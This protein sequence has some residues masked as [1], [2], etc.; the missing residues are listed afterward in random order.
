MCWWTSIRPVGATGAGVPPHPQSV[1]AARPS[2]DHRSM[3]RLDS[4]RTAARR[5]RPPGWREGHAAGPD[6]PGFST[7]ARPRRRRRDAQRGHR[8]APFPTAVP[9]RR[10]DHAGAR[11]VGVGQ[12]GRERRVGVPGARPG[13]NTALLTVGGGRIGCGAV[14]RRRGFFQQAVWSRRWPSAPERSLLPRSSAAVP[15]V[16]P[17]DDGP[18][19]TTGRSP[20]A[21]S[22]ST[23]AVSRTVWHSRGGTGRPASAARSVP[24]HHGDGPVRGARRQG[25]R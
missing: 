21:L 3:S 19:V 6:R 10:R 13:R 4:S 23:T 7:S 20:T 8:R 25:R 1:A 14:V 16:A 22:P 5:S 18:I 2:A 15:V 11:V 24:P 12:K 17:V 9:G